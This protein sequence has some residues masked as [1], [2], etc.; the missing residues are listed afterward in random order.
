AVAVGFLEV[1]IDVPPRIDDGRRARLLVTDE[2]RR[3][4]EAVEVEL[5]E[6]HRNPCHILHE[7]TKGSRR[8]QRG[9]AATKSSRCRRPVVETA[10][11][12]APRGG[13]GS[14]ARNGGYSATPE[15]VKRSTP[16]S[17]MMCLPQRIDREDERWSVS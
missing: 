12:W 10:T 3:L 8:T 7:G 17:G 11:A 14:V 13:C 5:F 15:Y 1:H 4:R 9:G 2:I 6:N 16:V